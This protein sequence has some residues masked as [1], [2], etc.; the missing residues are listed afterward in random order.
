ME[1][2]E[3]GGDGRISVSIYF[4]SQQRKKE[5][6]SIEKYIFTASGM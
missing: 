3:G 6:G 1:E 2:G 5:R 4:R